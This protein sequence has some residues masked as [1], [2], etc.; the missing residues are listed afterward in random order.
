MVLLVSRKK[1]GPTRP[2]AERTTPAKFG[3]VEVDNT[4]TFLVFGAFTESMVGTSLGTGPAPIVR[5]DLTG[6][7]NHGAEDK[8]VLMMSPEVAREWARH[9]KEGADAAEKDLKTYL[10]GHVPKTGEPL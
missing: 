7:W 3:Y 2:R 6:K 9:L 5:A 1:K 8:P 4:R 10:G